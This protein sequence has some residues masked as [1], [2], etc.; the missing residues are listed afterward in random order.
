MLATRAVG[1]EGWNIGEEGWSIGEEGWCVGEEGWSI[2]A[3]EKRVDTYS[4][5]GHPP[6]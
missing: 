6:Y 3:S 4:G 2:G 5:A 1:A